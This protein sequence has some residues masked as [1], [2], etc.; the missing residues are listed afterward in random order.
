MFN[1]GAAFSNKWLDFLRDK[2]PGSIVQVI[3]E[4]R[5]DE[6]TLPT[7]LNRTVTPIITEGTEVFNINF[8]PKKIGN[9]ILIEVLL[10]VKETVNVGNLCSVTIFKDTI[11]LTAAQTNKNSSGGLDG[12]SVIIRKKTGIASLNAINLQIRAGYDGAAATQKLNIG[13][14]DS[15]TH[16]FGGGML[17]TS[18]KITE[19]QQ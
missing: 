2:Q 15:A 4:E 9:F 12:G 18:I 3:Y 16:N 17:T 19:I 11:P 13:G 8:T 5:T 1:I 10:Y 14:T 7:A 6:L